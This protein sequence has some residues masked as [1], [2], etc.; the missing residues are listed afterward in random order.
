MAVGFTYTRRLT[1]TVRSYDK[2]VTAQGAD[3]AAASAGTTDFIPVDGLTRL[4]FIV[5]PDGT[6]TTYDI[7]VYALLDGDWVELEAEAASGLSGQRE[8]TIDIGFPSLYIRLFN[9][10][11]TGNVTTYVYGSPV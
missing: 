1:N 3:D 4:S 9:I 2:R 11:G 7:S 5:V 8:R 10:G 6:I